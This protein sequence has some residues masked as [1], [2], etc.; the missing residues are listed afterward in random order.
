[1][2]I[3]GW[4]IIICIVVLIAI[5]IISVY[6]NQHF[7]VRSY[8][9][10][11]KKLP[12]AFH[13]FKIAVI[14]D[15]HNQQFGRDNERLLAAI[16]ESKPDIVL[17]AGDLLVG[18]PKTDFSVAVNLVEHLAKRYPV[19]M[20]M[21]NHEYRLRIYPEDY[22]DMWKRYYDLTSKAGAVWLDNDTIFI[23]RNFDG[24]LGNGGREDSECIA[25]TGLTMDARYYRRFRRTPMTSDYVEEICPYTRRDLFQILLAH[26]PDYFPE[27]VAYGADLVISGHIH[28][29]MMRLPVLGGVI[30]PMFTLFPKYDQGEFIE[31]KSR[32]LLSAGLGNH[33]I[34]LRVNNKPELM[35]IELK[36]G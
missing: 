10:K 24:H 12:E 8:L 31:G 18:K 7:V 4:F 3:L 2:K 28:G 9:V 20:A 30:S 5:I 21:G 13:G 29:G 34:K 1:M 6:E 27:Y 33:T 25:L 16:D 11:N 26:N 15:L 36:N 19:Y 35:M 32:M 23:H 17:C 14:S 22:G